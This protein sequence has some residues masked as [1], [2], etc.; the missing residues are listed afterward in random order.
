M[1]KVLSVINGTINA[2]NM[3]LKQP[4]HSYCTLETTLGSQTFVC[5]DSSLVTFVKIHGVM[6]ILSATD[7]SNNIDILTERLVPFLSRNGYAF[8]IMFTCDSSQGKAEIG[9]ILQPSKNTLKNFGME[10]D[11]L[12]EDWEK[13][14]GSYCRKEELYI[15]LWTRPEVLN[16]EE[17][18]RAAKKK[19]KNSSDVLYTKYSQNPVGF[20]EALVDNHRQY[21]EAMQ[22]AF[23]DI[24]FSY[25]FLDVHEAVKMLRKQVDSEYTG[26]EWKAR[27]VGDPLPLGMPDYADLDLTNALLPS[28]P[29]QI[30]PR[31]G[32][33][34]DRKTILIGDNYHSPFCIDLMPQKPYP[35]DKL[36]KDLHDKDFPWRI[37]F[38]IEPDG[39]G[40]LKLFTIL[41]S[42]FAFTNSINKQYNQA[43]KELEYLQLEQNETIVQFSIAFD[44]WINRHEDEALKK[45]SSNVNTFVGV[46]QS[47]GACEVVDVLGD[48][49]LGVVSSISGLT[50]KSCAKRTAAPLVSAVSMLPIERQCSPWKSGSLCFRTPDGRPYPYSPSSSLQSSWID[51]GFAPMGQGK[52]VLLNTYNFGFLTQPGLI[53]IPFLTIIDVGPSSQGLI[54]LFKAALPDKKHLFVYE[55][56][57]NEAKYSI[58]PFDTPLGFR[59]PTANHKSFLVNLLIL[60]CTPLDSDAPPTGTDGILMEAI[61]RAYTNYDDKHN[62]KLFRYGL[63]KTVD[64]IVKTHN[65]CKDEFTTW[66]EITDQLFDLGYIH[67]AYQAQRHAMPLLEEIGAI[68]QEPQLQKKYLININGEDLPHYVWRSLADARRSYPV[69]AEPTKFD[70]GDA[71]VVSLD[72]DKVTPKE[73]VKAERQANIFFMLARFVGGS[74]FYFGKDDALAA[75]EKYKEY[76]L[77]I[78]SRIKRE[79][80]RICYDEA[81][82]IFKSKSSLV[83]QIITDARESRKW[84]ISIGLYSQEILDFPETIIELSS[85]VFMLGANTQKMVRLLSDMYHLNDTCQTELGRIGKPGRRGSKMICVFKTEQGKALQQIL[86]S[87]LGSSMI[88]AFSS[89]AEDTAVRDRLI[90]EFGIAK[91]LKALSKYHGGGSIKGLAEKLKEEYAEKGQEVDV[92]SLI[93]HD[94]A[95]KIRIE[96]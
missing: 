30:F 24:G 17:S 8:Q 21:V 49:L 11:V 27:L 73:G 51:I 9:D 39:L 70:L 3:L 47:W 76:H 18:K 28:I 36:Y 90:E 96:D 81:H 37:S 77:D 59:H 6:S 33:D 34:I 78:V 5:N 41:S 63:E 15:A 40:K 57:S 88:W 25:D 89:T 95:E 55:R 64:E 69:F 10:I 56:L 44:T 14:L 19:I 75:P 93:T 85:N 54:N 35:F 50:P 45:L 43:I 82:R 26:K 29:Q 67:E 46:V 31:E 48:P 80:K 86:F 12:F 22:I 92:I 71:K 7:F 58:N 4:V 62:P 53:D 1:E 61:E 13:A 79:P 38:L 16:K 91:T 72:L 32:Y 42:I 23:S 83:N 68:V 87:T 2:F 74:K 84:N 20:M 65:L 66:W 60:L 52:S 94:L